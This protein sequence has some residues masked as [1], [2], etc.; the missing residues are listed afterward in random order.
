MCANIPAVVTRAASL[1]IR[2]RIDLGESSLGPGK[3][4]LLEHIHSSG[5]LSQAARELNMS[6]RRAWLLLDDLNH[7]FSEPV[8]TASVGGAGG[9]GAQL[10]EFGRKLVETFRELEQASRDLA[11][12][13]LG[14]LAELATAHAG[15]L[16]RR[17]LSRSRAAGAAAR[18][19]RERIERR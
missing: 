14:W 1:G 2:L 15:G 3:I 8:S 6:Y 11:G 9:G 7:A 18:E 19:R 16:P 12:R 5:S 17:S 4:A 13:R 10:T